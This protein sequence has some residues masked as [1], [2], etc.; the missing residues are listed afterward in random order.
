M[1]PFAE[2]LVPM[3]GRTVVVVGATSWIGRAMARVAVDAG[4]NVMLVGRTPEHLEELRA[5]LG[6]DDRTAI[7]TADLTSQ[8]EV[9]AARQATLVRFGRV[10]VL[11]IAVGVITGSAFVEGVPA[12]WADMI[13][14]NLRGLLHAAQAFTDPLVT[15]AARGDQADLVLVRP[16]SHD[17]GAPVFAVFD[18]VSAAVQR[19]GRTL[20]DE[21]GR[22]GVRVHMIEP[23]FRATPAPSGVPARLGFDMEA[24]RASA[25]VRPETVAALVALAV[26]L[27]AGVNLAELM[28]LPAGDGASS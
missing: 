14:V 26:S 6:A 13:D 10:D 17:G 11:V 8:L 25:E 12:D 9:D 15:T 20:R 23:G 2:Q 24:S 19:F 21:L 4:A 27:P 7:A 16:V 5:Q 22:D 18:A 28:V 3:P 1:I